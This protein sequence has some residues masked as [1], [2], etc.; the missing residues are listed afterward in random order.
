MSRNK[1]PVK[2]KKRLG[3]TFYNVVNYQATFEAMNALIANGK[4]KNKKE[5]GKKLSEADLMSTT[6]C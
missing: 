5:M 3:L 2:K 6:S 1:K 4:A